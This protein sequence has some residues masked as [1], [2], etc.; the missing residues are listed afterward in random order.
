M[1]SCK[2]FIS[3]FIF[4]LLHF[5]SATP[6]L[7]SIGGLSSKSKSGGWWRGEGGLQ[8]EKRRGKGGESW[9]F[10]FLLLSSSSPHSFPLQENG[11]HPKKE[12]QKKRRPGRERKWV[13]RSIV[14]PPLKCIYFW[15]NLRFPEANFNIF[16]FF[17]AINGF[18]TNSNISNI[19]LCTFLQSY[20]SGGP[21]L[22]INDI[23]K[24]EFST[25]RDEYASTDR[26]WRI[27]SAH[28]LVKPIPFRQNGL[29]FFIMIFQIFP[30]FLPCALPRLQLALLGL[31]QVGRSPHFND[32]LM[33]TDVEEDFSRIKNYFKS[34][35]AMQ[36]NIC[37]MM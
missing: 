26:S 32:L 14:N 25:W 37:R 27:Q 1:L 11:R 16:L 2:V 3:I 12:D 24:S 17:T 18:K 31:L 23:R 36:Y 9:I 22:N 6:T 15:T 21:A 20:N 4:S 13:R 19:L 29:L 5:I 30:L 28:N 10:S 7:E 33:T 35:F 8:E 34:D